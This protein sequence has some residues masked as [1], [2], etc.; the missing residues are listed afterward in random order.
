LR[1]FDRLSQRCGGAP[2][3]FD[4]LSQR[5]GGAP[6]GFDRLSQ[7]F[8]AKTWFIVTLQFGLRWSADFSRLGS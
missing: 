8:R 5:C 7:R 1:G 2:R 3:G 6:R 4:R